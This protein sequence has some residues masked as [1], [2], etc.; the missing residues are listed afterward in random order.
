MYEVM[1]SALQAPQAHA[2]AGRGLA[3]AGH[4]P[5]HHDVAQGEVD[6]GRLAVAQDHLARRDAGER[7]GSRGGQELDA[8]SPRGD[9]IDH[10]RSVRPRPGTAPAR[11][12]PSPGSRVVSADA[13]ARERPAVAVHRA[14]FDAPAL[15]QHDSDRRGLL[16]GVH[17]RDRRAWATRR[18]GGSPRRSPGPPARRGSRRPRSTRSGRRAPPT[19][20]SGPARRSR[21]R[22]G[23]PGRR[24]PPPC[25]G[26][27]R[28]P[29]A[30]GCRPR[31]SCPR[32]PARP[33]STPLPGRWP[34]PAARSVRRRRR[35][36]RTDPRPRR[37]PPNAPPGT[38]GPRPP[39]P[40][41]GSR[42]R[43][44][45][46]PRPPPG[47]R[48]RLPPPSRGPRDPRRP[49]PWRAPGRARAARR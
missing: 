24:R 41:R 1:A 9:V 10:E 46:P 44:A 38:A 47:R 3:A 15:E 8:R 25:P 36:A 30:G 32:R 2:N 23:C 5:R 22:R 12:P 39:A 43:P 49:G 7:A 21:W 13:P 40:R 37:R 6:G 20:G 16:P 31:S 42:P 35:A 48:S 29:G 18:P 27:C 14:P 34:G 45:G 26:R 33:R 28:R 4:A 19:A 11:S 17:L